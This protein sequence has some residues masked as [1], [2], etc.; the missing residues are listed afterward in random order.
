M[1]QWRV[2]T[3]SMGSTLVLLGI[4]IFISQWQG[5]EALESLIAWWP[6][7]FVLLGVEILAYIA[8]SRMAQPI[9]KYD[10]LSIMF[11]GFICIMCIGFV[12]LAATGVLREFRYAVN[13]YEHTWDVPHN[14]E[15]MTEQISRIVV[16]NM[17]PHRVLIDYSADPAVHV[18]G[19]LHGVVTDEDGERFSGDGIS[20]IRVIGDTMYVEIK[21]PPRRSSLFIDGFG[22]FGGSSRL[23]VTVV[24]PRGVDAVIHGSHSLISPA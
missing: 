16:Q 17:Q 4:L 21:L 23:N 7:V 9:V 11:V 2:G 22:G 5:K 3:I 10:M 14:Q 1:K 24:L 15:Q 13:A 8:L 19:S 20:D 18:F 12:T 6:V